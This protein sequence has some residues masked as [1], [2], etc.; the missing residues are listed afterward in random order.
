MSDTQIT[1]QT[2]QLLSA[3]A[4]AKMLSLSARTVWRYRSS[5]QLPR[6]VKVGGAIRW[7]HTDIE[8]W[9]SMDCP[10]RKTFEARKGAEQCYLK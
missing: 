10:D 5:D 3:K 7:R 9:I 8:K 2:C 4:L 6:P 1:N